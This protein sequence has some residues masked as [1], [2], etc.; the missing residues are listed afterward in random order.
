MQF[1]M[2][3]WCTSNSQLVP[4]HQINSVSFYC[5]DEYNDII[6]CYSYISVSELQ[7][8]YKQ[9]L[10]VLNRFVCSTCCSDANIFALRS[11]FTSVAKK[12]SRTG[13]GNCVPRTDSNKIYILIVSR[14]ECALTHSCTL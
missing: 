13:T 4:S 8:Q 10:N 14:Q 3:S 11:T 7:L 12:L 9:I 5:M 2:D 6:V 1:L